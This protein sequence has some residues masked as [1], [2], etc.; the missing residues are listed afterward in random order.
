MN[1]A[2]D[3]HIY[4]E[5]QEDNKFEVLQE[6]KH[7]HREGTELVLEQKINIAQAALG[8]TILV[9]TLVKGEKAKVNIKAG[10]QNGE[11]YRLKGK[12]F[13]NLQGFGKGDMHI[14]IRVTTPKKLSSREKEL[15]TELNDLWSRTNKD[16]KK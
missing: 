8:D 3:E 13:P 14:L 1:N 5:W 6:H 7:F 10:T 15:F 2:Q 12:G 11:I 16:E 4:A 9:P